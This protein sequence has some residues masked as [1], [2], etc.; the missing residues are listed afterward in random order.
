MLG[1]I[2]QLPLYPNQEDENRLPLFVPTTKFSVRTPNKWG[3]RKYHP[4]DCRHGRVLLVDDIYDPQKLFIWDPITGRQR[5]LHLPTNEFF[6]FGVAVLCANTGCDHQSCHEGPSRV[7]FFSLTNSVDG[8]SVSYVRVYIWEIGQWSEQCSSLH[9]GIEDAFFETMSPVVIENTV[10]LMI[11]D[12]Y[13]YQPIPIL[14]Y[15]LAS[16][17][18]SQMDTPVGC[19]FDNC[20]LMAMEDGCLG[21]AHLKGLTLHIWSRRMGSN[22][23]VEWTQYKIINL[24]DLIH[25]QVPKNPFGPIGSIEGSDIIFL[26]TKLGIYKINVKSLLCKKLRK[27]EKFI[28]LIPYM[29]FYTPQGMYMFSI[30]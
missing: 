13:D 4:M 2:Y 5:E 7:V 25:I 23:V 11:S 9:I 19:S 10:Y 29:S 1:F 20:L 21:F 3:N 6:S 22:R 26:T 16:N 28:S 30:L 12:D 15:N 17:C 24:N 18:L 27:K 8:D 14:S